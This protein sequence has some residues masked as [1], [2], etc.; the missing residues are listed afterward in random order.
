MISIDK[1]IKVVGG[2][3]RGDNDRRDDNGVAPLHVNTITEH[4][5]FPKAL[6]SYNM[7]LDKLVSEAQNDIGLLPYHTLLSALT[8]QLVIVTNRSASSQILIRSARFEI[9][10]RKDTS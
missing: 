6:L 3:N 5:T 9:V 10:N 1:P 8:D 2:F 7:L 4:Q